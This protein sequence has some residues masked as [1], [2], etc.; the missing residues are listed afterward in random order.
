[1]SFQTTKRLYRNTTGNTYHCCICN[2]T[3]QNE[4]YYNSI[5]DDSSIS[6]FNKTGWVCDS[7][8]CVNM[9]IFRNL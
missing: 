8:E 2:K 1:M 3:L 7:E 4:F 6:I 9:Y 5:V